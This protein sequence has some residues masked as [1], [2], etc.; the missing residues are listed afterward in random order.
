M[1]RRATKLKSGHLRCLADEGG[2]VGTNSGGGVVGGAGA[3]EPLDAAVGYGCEGAEGVLGVVECSGVAVP[4]LL[5]I[6]SGGVLCPPLEESA[7]DEPKRA[8]A[9][10]GGVEVF[11]IGSAGEEGVAPDER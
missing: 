2:G 7:T 1:R 9:G 10:G 6:E 8:I 5:P 11:T 3:K 4:E